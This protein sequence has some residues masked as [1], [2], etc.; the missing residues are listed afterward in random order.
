MQREACGPL[1]WSRDRVGRDL[2]CRVTRSR[3][4]LCILFGRID[5]K[6]LQALLLAVIIKSQATLT[7]FRAFPLSE[8]FLYALADCSRFDRFLAPLVW[9]SVSSEHLGP[10]FLKLENKHA[11]L[12]AFT[13]GQRSDYEQLNFPDIEAIRTVFQRC[14]TAVLSCPSCC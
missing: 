14:I 6:V 9:S 13:L 12:R 10:V 2:V 11:C 8:E 3:Y 1:L 5:R 4:R 7:E